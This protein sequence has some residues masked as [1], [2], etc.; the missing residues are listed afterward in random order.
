MSSDQP[1]PSTTRP[2]TPPAAA[3]SEG[4]DIVAGPGR[5]YRNTRYALLVLF[6]AM[7]AWFALDGWKRYPEE[8]ARIADLQVRQ[9]AAETRGDQAELGRVNAE[10][11]NY[12]YHNDASLLLQ[13]VFAVVL[14][15][16]GIT[17]LIRALHNSRGAYRLSGTKLSVP[18]HP[19]INFSEIEEVDD[20]LWDRKG[21][22][23][24][25]YKTTAG[26]SGEL[27]LDDFVYDRPPTDAIYDRIAEHLG[28]N[29][30]DDDDED[31]E[32]EDDGAE[33]T[34]DAQN[35]H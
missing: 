5:Y 28:L 24:I 18:G 11:K 2:E 32:D 15:I 4:G 30:D 31:D 20:D 13:R 12:S 19:T 29:D 17:L 34:T 27:R 25:K 3:T 7:G 6:V 14:P 33:D 26:Q 1:E 21:I 23:Y 10:L 22:A 35:R 16:L 9:K 8:N